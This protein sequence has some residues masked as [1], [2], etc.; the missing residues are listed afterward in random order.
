MLGDITILQYSLVETIFIIFVIIIFC[1]FLSMKL[2]FEIGL[3]VPNGKVWKIWD[4]TCARFVQIWESS[5]SSD[6]FAQ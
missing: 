2:L 3:F 1:L 6:F 4:R 5:T